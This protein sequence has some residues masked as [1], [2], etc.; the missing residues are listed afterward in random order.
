MI[1]SFM[2]KRSHTLARLLCVTIVAAMLC[3]TFAGCSFLDSNN[4]TEPSSDAPGL[5]QTPTTTAPSESTSTTTAPTTEPEKQNV[6]VV[7]QQTNL[8]SWPS[9]E[10]NILGQVDAGEE[11]EVN[12]IEESPDG[13]MWAYIPTRGWVGVDNLDMTNVQGVTGSNGTPANPDATEPTTGSSTDAAGNKT[14]TPTTKPATSVTTGNGQKG[15]VVANDLNIRKEAN[16]TS[17]SVGQ[18][19]YGTRVT[20]LESSNGW[21][22]IDKG[23]ISLNYVYLDGKTGSKPCKGFVSGSVLNVRSGPGTNYDSVGSL[24]NGARVDVLERIDVNG[25]TWGC[26]KTGWISMDY[27]FVDGTVGEGAGTGTVTGDGVNIRSGPGTN[28]GVVGSVSSGEVIEITSQMTNGDLT[29]G[30]FS[31]GW[32]CMDYVKMG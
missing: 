27:V 22:R 29:W 7:K 12:R 3:A 19:D 9:S 4:N 20:I 24:A 5:L 31:K 15:V 23:W 13:N 18:L 21:G 8:R 28:Y 26:T 16:T 11:V 32:I 10:A 6:A 14:T 17:D 1:Y 30:C 25:T 2:K